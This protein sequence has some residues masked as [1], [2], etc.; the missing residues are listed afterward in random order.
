MSLAGSRTAAV[1]DGRKPLI[2]GDE[3]GV[4]ETP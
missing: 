4:D 2:P 3:A 1:M